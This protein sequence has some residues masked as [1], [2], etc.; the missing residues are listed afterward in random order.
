VALA[1]L[2]EVWVNAVAIT[3]KPELLEVERSTM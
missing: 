2:Y 3:T 1:S